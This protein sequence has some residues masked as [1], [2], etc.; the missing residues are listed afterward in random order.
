MMEKLETSDRDSPVSKTSVFIRIL[1]RTCF[2]PITIEEDGRRLIF[3]FLSWKTLAYVIIYGGCYSLIS[4]LSLSVIDSEILTKISQENTIETSSVFSS[5]ISCVSLLFPLILARGL[6]QVDLHQVWD[7][8]LTFPRHGVK[9]II[10]YIWFILGALTALSD[11][12]MHLG[13][14]SQDILKLVSSSILRNLI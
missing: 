14:P 10:S 7:G 8:Q 4:L 1:I 5:S 9:T 3:R 6:D 11:Y 13:F 2:L 12:L